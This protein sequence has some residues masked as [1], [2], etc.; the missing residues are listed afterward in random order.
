MSRARLVLSGVSIALHGYVGWRL[1][2]GLALSPWVKGGVIAG[3]ATSAYLVPLGLKRHATEADHQTTWVDWTSLISMGW[4]SSVWVLTILRD[5]TF[6]LVWLIDRP[7]MTQTRELTSLLVPTL[8]AI[9]SA[10]GF[11][12]ARQCAPVRPVTVPLSRLPDALA[13]LRIVQISDIHVGPT[14][15]KDYLSR[16]VE[17]VNSLDA[18]LVVVTGDW[19]DG[20]VEV[21]GEEVK[22]FADLRARLGVYFVNGNHDYYSGEAA[23]TA[24]LRRLGCTVLKNKHVILTYQGQPFVLAGV[25]DYTAHHFNPADQSDPKKSLEGAPED[26]FKILLAHQPRSLFAA[27]EAGFDLQLSGHTHGGQFWPWKYFVP[28]QQ[29]LV[30]GLH[31]VGK[32]AVYVSR[33]TG[34]WGPPMRLDATAEITLLTLMPQRAPA[35]PKSLLGRLKA[36]LLPSKAP[37]AVGL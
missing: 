18:D 17:R 33:G 14:I 31:Y 2:S 8:A 37:E 9:G 20:R 3:L 1:T 35:Q 32:L 30:E 6:A 24:H 29:P 10:W 15:R 22:P 4:F 34:Y 21:I 12:R 5:S 36:T 23:W 27:Q 19:V 11:Y 7:V 16:I 28:L 25:N 26:L 13:G